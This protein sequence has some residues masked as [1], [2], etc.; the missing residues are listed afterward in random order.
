[1]RVLASGSNTAANISVEDNQNTTTSAKIYA[2]TIQIGLYTGSLIQI[3]N[4]AST[5]N[6]QGTN[7]LFDTPLTSSN[8]IEATY[9]YG[10]GSQLTFG[11]TDIVSGSTQINVNET[12]NFQ[13]FSG[14]VHSRLGTLEG[15]SHTHPNKTELDTINQNL[16]KT[17]N[18]I[19][20]DITA[21]NNLLVNGD[22]TVIGSAT[23][24]YS[25]ELTI[26]DKLITLASGSINSV[27]ADGA[28][29]EIDG[30]NQSLTWNAVNGRWNLSSGISSSFFIGDGSGIANVTAAAVEYTDVLNK[31]TL[32]SGSDQV[33]QS[34]DL[35]YLEITGDSVVSS[36]A[37]ISNYNTFL[38]INGDDVVSGSSQIDLTQTTNYV[39]GIKTRLNTEGIFSGSSQV[40]FNDIADNPIQSNSSELT[41]TGHLVPSQDDTYDLGTATSRWRTLYV[42]AN[43]IDLGGTLLS[44]EAG[45]GNVQF[46]D[47][48]SLN[49][50]SAYVDF[51]TIL[52]KPTLV[53]GSSEIDLTQTTNY[54]SGIKTRLN[55]ELVVSGSDQV[56]GSLDFRYLEIN[57]DSVFSSSEQVNADDITNF[58]SNVKDKLNVEG[59]IS[60]SE[61]VSFIDIINKPT[62]VSG[63]DQVTESLD[64]RYLEIEGDGVVSGST[65]IDVN[66]TQNFQ[67]FSGSVDNR[68]FTVESD[69]HNHTNKANLDV[70]D[71]DLATTDKPTFENINLPNLSSLPISTE[72]SVLLYSESGEFVYSELGTAAYYHVSQSISQEDDNVIGTAGAM[73]RYI[74]EQLLIIGAGDITEVNGGDGLN[75]G[76]LSGPVTLSLDIGSSH[77]TNGVITALPI[78][79]VSGSSQILDGSELVSSSAQIDSLGFLQVDGDSVVSGSSQI[80]VTATTNYGSINQYSDTKVKT[81]LDLEG[82][83]SGSSQ[84]LEGSGII[85]SSIQVDHDQTTNY[86][87]GEHFLQSEITTLGTVTTGNVTSILPIGTVSGSSQILDGS[88]IVSSSAQIDSL[89]FLQVNGDSIVSSSQ[90]I[91]NYNTF[92]EIN[93]MG[94][95][96]GSSQLSGSLVTLDTDQTISGTKTFNDIVVNGTGSFAYITSTNGTAKIIGDAFV[97]VNTDT[98]TSR[99]AG[100]S[101]YDSGSTL[102]TAS[103][104]FDGETNDWGYEYSSSV[105]VDY[106]VSIFGPEYNTKGNP[107][108]LTSNRIPKAVDNHH[109]NDSNISDSGTLITLGSNTIIEGTLVASGTTLVSGSSQVTLGGDVT[110]TA[111]ANTV[112]KI[113]GVSIT[114][115]EATQLANINAT[116]ISTTQWGYV[117]ELNQGLTTTSNVQFGVISGS[118]IHSEGTITAEGDVVAYVSSD[119]RLKDEITPIENSLQKINSIGGYS[120]VWNEKQNIYKGKDYGIIAQ[121]IENILP[122]LVETRENGYKAVKYDRIVSL[123]IEGVKELSKEV[124]ELKKQIGK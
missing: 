45:T 43:T 18:V 119:E 98:P 49:V 40:I 107:T 57:G 48:A 82:V 101:V 122:E 106:A 70:I 28:G 52:N 59:V 77:F 26:T 88:E 110:G 25:T 47:S 38:E 105:G 114:S 100:L 75:G 111:T 62:L 87:E 91:S 1:M 64:L 96:S 66:S 108:Y 97:V 37:Q 24:I 78:G 80:D 112:G 42:G 69:R 67:T 120:F 34:L 3:G 16:S 17:S 55:S 109:L 54:V 93:G 15:D 30:A 32:V 61:Q 89:G 10:D 79:T 21:S 102:S 35:R 84:I 13:T 73:K 85:S 83:I 39:S 44:R 60:G 51:S 63:S 8:T 27:A 9:F 2:D 5:I 19:F 68:L 115:G 65:Q 20:N 41:V 36:S 23:E 7:L 76:A 94:V 31:P 81:K 11:G 117:G 71:Q 4:P 99:Y 22:L 74:D 72:F 6:L 123:L 86:V 14:S 104:Y 29:I 46:F 95:I 58:D 103:F 33:T 56:T 12:Q 53:S 90:Q 121:E 116:T 113:Q 124:S 50:L 92:L 118:A